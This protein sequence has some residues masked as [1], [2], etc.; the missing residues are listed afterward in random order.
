MS[1]T[2]KI[3]KAP[4][5]PVELERQVQASGYGIGVTLLTPLSRSVDDQ[6]READTVAQV[7]RALADTG[8]PADRLIFEV[9]EGHLVEDV[10]K[11]LARLHE[12]AAL[13]I[14][15]LID[16]FGSGYS[17]PRGYLYARPRPLKTWL[18]RRG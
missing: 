1:V 5:Q 9:T 14:R 17:S 11:V 10:D 3:R 4:R 2:K 15:F 13:G 8:A 18:A 12:L 6:L 16:D 7:R